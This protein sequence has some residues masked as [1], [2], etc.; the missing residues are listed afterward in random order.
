[1]RASRVAGVLTS[2]ARGHA[3]GRAP[4]QPLAQRRNTGRFA[5]SGNRPPKLGCTIGARGAGAAGAALAGPREGGFKGTGKTT[6]ERGD[7]ARAAP[8]S[9]KS[10]ATSSATTTRLRLTAV[11][12]VSLWNDD[13]AHDRLG[14]AR[15]FSAVRSVH[16]VMNRRSKEI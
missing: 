9:P 12:S 10:T 4:V 6:G 14:G 16:G 5:G 11:I 7:C 8:P 13:P 15:T 2:A 3:A 1:M